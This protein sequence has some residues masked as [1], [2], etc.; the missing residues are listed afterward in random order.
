V[1]DDR[2]VGFP[3]ALP[4]APLGDRPVHA[5]DAA[6]YALAACQCGNFTRRQVLAAGGTD[7]LIA[8]RVAA[9]R[10]LVVAEGVYS[11]PGVA[12]SYH[13]GLWVAWLAAPP[14]AV[15]SHWSGGALRRLDGFP[16]N[17]FTISVPHGGPRRNPVARVFQSRSMPAATPVDG[18][19]VAS[20]ERILVDMG[21][22]VGPKKLEHLVEANRTSGR[23]N[24]VRLR[25]EFLRLARP[26]R[27]GISTM[28]AVLATYEDGP[29]PSRRDLEGA[30]DAILRTIPATARREAPL[31]GREW[32]G[33]RVD[34]LFEHPRRLIVEGDGRRWH[35][36]LADFRR[37]RQRDRDA[38]R[39]GYPTVRYAYEEL[40]Q[41]AASVRAELVE[42]LG[43]LERSPVGIR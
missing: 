23:T 36:R 28:R 37:D 3:R 30:L 38:L 32:S 19:P 41:D 18:L 13:R 29:T 31:P 20:V 16:R 15:I 21:R 17:R 11:L 40:T 2:D 27:N 25:R 34:R 6:I 12:P 1:D 24:P 9:G 43:T 14:T 39:A 5:V 42:L 26:G 33:D 10:W 22:L 4:F 35:T 7:A 8:R